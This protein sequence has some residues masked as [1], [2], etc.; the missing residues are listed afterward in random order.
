MKNNIFTLILFLLFISGI[1][2]NS[3]YE[4]GRRF[5]PSIKNEKINEAKYVSEIM[6][7]FCRYFSLP[8]KDR[9]LFEDQ[10]KI[11]DSHNEGYVYHLYPQES[12]F[13]E[14]NYEKV[15]DF[16]S[17]EISAVCQGKTLKSQSSKKTLTAE[18]KNILN[19]A[20]LGTDIRIKIK[21]KY[22]YQAIEDLD[23]GSKVREGEYIV[24]VV[25][26]TEAE[27]SGGFKQM[28]EYIKKSI[29]N[30]IPEKGVSKKIQQAVLKF[31]VNEE[32]QII[33]TKISSTSTDPKI[34][35]LILDATNKMPKWKPAQNSK[36][37]KVK[38]EFSIQFGGGGC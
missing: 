29:I 7:Q 21:F 17:V 1:A 12:F 6:P 23:S 26:E 4:F 36:G 37:V 33:D 9:A 18:Q 11:A 13:P 15:I 3:K 8:S 22:K 31:T 28:T 2:Q 10:V 27:Y 35:K 19:N 34:D 38:E 32:G 24:T 25:P 30:K 20:D 14:E 5:T 16:V